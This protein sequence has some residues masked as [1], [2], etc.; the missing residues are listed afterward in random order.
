MHWGRTRRA[1]LLATLI[2]G[3]VGGWA[4]TV[5]AGGNTQFRNP[6]NLSQVFTRLRDDRML[7][8]TWVMSSDGLPGSGLSNATL[9]AELQTAFDTW[10]ALPTS[11]LDFTFG[12]EVPLRNTQQGGPLGAGIDGRNL[13]TFTDPDV[14]FPPGVLAFAITFSFSQD[15]VITTANNDL[16]GD[17]IGD[18]PTGTYAAG[19]I[20]DGDIAF[21]SSEPWS[22]TGANGSI[23]VRAVALHEVGHSFGLCH[24]MIRDA[25]MWPFLAFDI[26][27]ARTPKTDDIAYASFFYPSQPAFGNT[28]GA[29]RGQVINGFSSA[30]VLGAHV[31]SV[32]PLSGHSVV[33]AFSGDNGSYVIPGLAAGNYLVAIEPLDGDPVGL[34]PFRI[35][36]VVQF[37][38]D[39]N[40]PEE[41]YDANESNVEA[42]PLAGQAVAVA[43]GVDTSDINLVTNSLQVPGVNRILSEGYNLFAYPV[44]VPTEL[45]AFE[46]LQALGDASEINAIDRFV[47]GTSAFE[48]AEYVGSTPSG[49]NFAIRRGEAYVVHMDAQKV[50]SFAGGTDCPDLDLARGLN[51]VGIP[52]PP[53]GYTAFKL[54]KDL[55]ESF[56]VETV[57]RFNPDTVSFQGA[58]YNS[59][60]M[61]SGDDFPIS[62]GE[63]YIV[64]MLADKAGIKVPA[65]GSSFAPVLKGLSPGRGVP[66]TLVVILGEGFDPDATKDVVSF[67]GVGA[68][69]IFATSTTLTVTVPGA[70]STGPV[71]VTVAGRQSNAIDFVVEPAVVTENPAGDTELVSGQ[72][73]EGTLSVDGEQ[74]RYVFTALAG[75][76]VT[77]HAEAVTPG[78]P[79]LVL[80]LED[81]FGVAVATDDNSGGGTNPRINNFELPNT[82]THTVVVS[83]VPGS[84]T[85]AYRLSLTI[86]TRSAPIQ[87][88]ILGGNFQT[89]LAG[90][91]LPNPLSV[92]VTGATGAPLSGTQVTLVATDATIESSSVNPAN[93]G[94]VVL[95]T[96]PSGVITVETT[97]PGTPGTYDI[98]VTVEGAAPVMFHVA[99]SNT[100]IAQVVM[101][102]DGQSGTVGMPL[103][104][105][106]EIIV[107]DVDG[108]GVPNAL[109]AFRVASGGGAV[110]N[111]DP[112]GRLIGGSAS[113]HFT[114]GTSTKEAQVVAAFAPGLSK[115]L[116][117]RA[118][119]KA[120]QPDHARSN[121]SNFNRMTLGTARLNA[122]QIEVFDLYDNPIEGVL[123]D[124]NAPGDLKIDP[125]LGPGGVFFPDFM[126]NKD[127]LH[128]AMVTALE[129]GT[130]TID[131]FGNPGLASTHVIT[132]T[133]D[134]GTS[135]SQM[136]N[137]DV[138]MGP[139]M[140][141]S[142][143]QGASALIGEMLPNP[144]GKVVL[145]YERVDRFVD[146]N[147]DGRDDDNGDFRDEDFT[148]K[149]SKLVSGIT[150]NFEVRRED[151]ESEASVVGLQPTRTSAPSAVTGGNGIATVAVTL[152]DV[153]GTN[154]VI[155]RIDVIPVI[156]RFADGTI[157]DQ[158][159]FVDGRKFAESTKVIATPV[160]IT[161]NVI[162]QGSGIDFS[163]VQAS[164][165]GMMFFNGAVPPAVPPT[166]PEKLEITGDGGVLKTLNQSIVDHSAF[167]QLK[168]EYHPFR[169]RLTPNNM[170]EVLKV[171]DRA[172]N[173]QGS[174]TMQSF[175]FP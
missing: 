142:S 129:S 84:G 103:A 131:E 41:F 8:I 77:I 172:E 5:W 174:S 163:V 87:I 12:G 141:T 25:V 78:V 125:G 47:P 156:W 71:R 97:L 27:A 72:T 120:D 133:A 92:F 7:P 68:G 36:Q 39:T 169:P 139:T 61:P 107:K 34:D 158:K 11:K 26:A 40:F 89:G 9:L 52:C 16:D 75:S 140:V 123:V 161:V 28:F 167:R 24:S 171:R 60:G 4:G 117:F 90:T 159:M 166:F 73:A 65:P 14:L 96:S 168:I 66:G 134:G 1:G 20:F 113:T 98:T 79:N 116:L 124:Y 145:R 126:T 32:D 13:V 136:F 82:G 29:I 93:A 10:E 64:M 45:K 162:D 165:N 15:T 127:G 23:D 17:G 137:V 21:N 6:A 173:E 108:V 70:A 2:F 175:A 105:P 160:V 63:G 147:A 55:G 109:V 144:V 74:D 164:L 118:T 91:T 112:L 155:G 56:E 31:F 95:S 3:I 38:T 48:R 154:D 135:P 54:L 132:A 42:D 35:N 101:N 121:H 119:P 51:L 148:M 94:T 67:N 128:V 46:L 88:S 22:V 153:G 30:P 157:L 80:V 151:G 50:A 114:L 53:A 152:G 150:V 62:N 104:D 170:V 143:V 33:G 146:A 111:P 86:A 122:L 59:S 106:L 85:G 18:I 149:V 138:D 69:V 100:A 37:T 58:Q 44:T 102:G 19:T 110:D 115:P 57:Q 81:P 83:N 99:A 130:P 76:L 43:A 49:A